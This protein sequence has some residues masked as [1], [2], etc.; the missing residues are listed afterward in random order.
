M[1]AKGVLQ[2][3]QA[4][5]DSRALEKRKV[6]GKIMQKATILGNTFFQNPDLVSSLCEMPSPDEVN[7]EMMQVLFNVVKHC[8]QSE[9]IA[10]LSAQS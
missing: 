6:V 10:C 5:H 8:A 1:I 2:Y 7:E 4:Q 3:Q 9:K